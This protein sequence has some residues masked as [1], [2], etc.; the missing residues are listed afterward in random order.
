MLEFLDFLNFMEEEAAYWRQPIPTPS[1]PFDGPAT[2]QKSSRSRRSSSSSGGMHAEPSPLHLGTTRSSM[3]PPPTA[4]P[5]PS[6]FIPVL[7]SFA[8]QSS[9]SSSSSSASAPSSPHRSAQGRQSEYH[10]RRLSAP[11]GSAVVGHLASFSMPADGAYGAQMRRSSELPSAPPFTAASLFPPSSSSERSNWPPSVDSGPL[12]TPASFPCPPFALPSMMV[13]EP[14]RATSPQVPELPLYTISARVGVLKDNLE[15]ELSHATRSSAPTVHL[16]G[17]RRRESDNVLGE[18]Q[19]AGTIDKATR[20]T[21]L[22]QME[23]SESR[24]EKQSAQFYQQCYD[25]VDA[26]FRRRGPE[27]ESRNQQA[28]QCMNGGR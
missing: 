11:P 4:K 15:G 7:P 26:P 17:K 25:H 19:R 20:Y 12:F 6:S 24:S 28:T 10:R 1:F 2:P 14:G 27:A 13:D 21:S 16:S 9:A 23:Q 22:Q 3:M 8:N 5:Q 18:Q